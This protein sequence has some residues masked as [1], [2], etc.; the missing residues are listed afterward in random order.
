ML[1]RRLLTAALILGVGA[2]LGGGAAS[3]QA[4]NV[5]QLDGRL[6]HRNFRSFDKF[7]AR[8]VDKVVGLKLAVKKSGS[9]DKLDAS[10]N[11]GQF[12][13]YVMDSKQPKTEVVANSGFAERSGDIV[14]DG[15]YLVK[16][17]GFRQGIHSYAL[18]PVD[19]AKV[20]LDPRLRIVTTRLK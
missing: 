3:A 15:F 9:D 5:D 16:Y 4:K 2:G 10:V 18:E 20:R 7:V 12:V 8:H 14:F 11:D 13:A 19:E 17:G 6:T 1:T